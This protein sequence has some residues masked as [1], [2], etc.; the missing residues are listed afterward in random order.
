[1]PSIGQASFA[2]GEIGAELYGRT[3]TAMYQVALKT[4]VNGFVRSS[5]GFERRPGLKFIAPVKDHSYTPRLVDFSFNT[6][7]VHTLEFGNLYMRVY[8]NDALVT[9]TA[10]AV[11]GITKANPGV[12]TVVGH[13]YTAG[14]DVYLSGIGGMAEL[15][16]RWVKVGTVLSAN[17]FNLA[18]Q[19]D[20]ANLDTS[21]FTTYTSGGTAARAY[22]LVTPY[23]TAD[24][25]ELNWTQSADVLTVVHRNHPPKEIKRL[26]L[27]N[28]TIT[29]IAFAPSIAAPA[30]PTITV[31]SAGSTNYSYIVTAVNSL[32]EESVGSAAATGTS[33]T[34][35]DNTVTIGAVA[36]AVSYNVYLLGAGKHGFIGSTT[37]LTFA[38][39]NIKPD[40]SDTPP[41]ARN[42]FSGAGK[43]PSAVSYYEQRRVFGGTTDA[44]DTSEY[45]RVA[46][47]SNMSKSEPVRD[48]DSITAT[49]TSQKVNSIRHYVPGNDLIIFTVGGEWRVNAGTDSAFSA[50]TLRQKPQST[51]GSSWKRPI[52]IGGTTLYVPDSNN[53]VRSLGF[54]LQI[55][56]YT[57]TDL[58]LLAPHL[59]KSYTIADW[60]SAKYPDT[61]IHAV[62][63]D[64]VVC[65]LTFQQEQEVIAWTRWATDGK[66]RAVACVGREAGGAFERTYFVV[67]RI[68]NGK[69]VR[70]VERLRS[71]DVVDVRDAFFV[72]CGATYDVP[73]AITGVSLANP[74]VV[75]APAHGLANNESVDISDIVWDP[76]YDSIF[77]P[78]NPAQL[79][80]GRFKVANST[81]NTFTLI[82][83]Q[84]APVNTT[85]FKKYIEGGFARKVVQ[86]LSGLHHLEGRTCVALVDGSV[87]ENLVV[88]RGSVTLPVRASRV[89][90]GL[91][92]ISDMETLDKS[93][94]QAVIDGKKKSVGRLAVRVQD[95]RGVLFGP[96]FSPKKMD[97]MKDRDTENYDEPTRLR[98]EIRTVV[99]PP[100]WNDHGR[101]CFRQVHPLPMV[102]LGV[103]PNYTLEEG[104]LRG[105]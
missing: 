21:S 30:T 39:K 42:P 17:T 80:G 8:R 2:K 85:A 58:N 9:E 5:G 43:Y 86:T 18:D 35:R 57:G 82:D 79:N 36:G 61:I 89:H 95:T 51:W 99:C 87:V 94:Q 96:S 26:G 31:N 38:D 101:L 97:E 15:N 104:E 23:T 37:S 102:I 19:V 56:G 1:M 60:A 93:T 45:S 25:F 76:T 3:D 49:L 77:G 53:R 50:A 7:D 10:K 48:D 46:A 22:T 47:Y 103:I 41:G 72:D 74:G 65:A 63:A 78:T 75:T 100:A 29:D 68:V 4:G 69:T 40:E 84:G 70:Y 91:R 92:Y 98:T 90:I 81:T 24:L 44:P 105:D 67:Q 11:T 28:W 20:G 16:G 73:I 54:S 6:T 52:T 88:T 34:T 14:E 71:Q 12:I 66:F 13:G 59:F 64:G 33:N 27:A 32:G 62:R 55:D 83:S